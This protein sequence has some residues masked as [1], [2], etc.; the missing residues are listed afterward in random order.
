MGRSIVEDG[1]SVARIDMICFEF[2]YTRTSAILRAVEVKELFFFESDA[3]NIAD[4]LNADH[5]SRRGCGARLWVGVLGVGFDQLKSQITAQMVISGLGIDGR[6]VLPCRPRG[7][8]MLGS[9]RSNQ[10]FFILS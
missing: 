7:L 10:D 8:R 2:V 9:L 5:V 6:G 4:Y 1:E 3:F